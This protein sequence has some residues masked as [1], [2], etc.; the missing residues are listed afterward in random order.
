MNKYF[1]IAALAFMSAT[2]AEVS[3]LEI[4]LISNLNFVCR[5]D[6]STKTTLSA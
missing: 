2:T 6:S 5:Q 4:I 1:S 3:H